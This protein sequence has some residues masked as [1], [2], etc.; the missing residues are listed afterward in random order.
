VFTTFTTA[1]GMNN[2][3]IRAIAQ[4][5]KG[6]MWFGGAVGMSRYDGKSFVNFSSADGLAGKDVFGL[7]FDHE[8]GLW[9][10]TS[11]GVS[12]YDQ[13]SVT[14][15]GEQ[16]GLDPGTVTSIVSTSDDNVWFKVGAN[17]AKLSRFDGKRLVKLTR[18][19]GLPG[20]NPAALY[21]DRDGA[22]LVSD[23]ETGRPVAR[24]DPASGSGERIRF[25]L[26]D[27]SGS[28]RAL[29]RSTTGELW[30]GRD[31]GAYIVGQPKES[32]KEIGRVQFAEPGRD[33]V[34]WFSTD[35]VAQNGGDSIW[36]YEPSTAPGGN[37]IWT[38]FPRVGEGRAYTPNV[39][40][41]LTLADGSLLAGT[42]NGA[43][44][45]DGKQF[46]PWPA[47]MPRLQ[48]LRI[49]NATRD[50]DGG[51][52]L[53]TAEGVFHTDGTAWNKLDLRDGLPENS[54]N[55]VHR[56]TD[57]TVWMGSF[58][59]GLARYRPIKHTPRSPLLTAQTDRDYTDVAALPTINT[60]QRVTFKFDVVDF[61]TAI[62]KRQYRWQLFQGARGEKEL[63]ANWQTPSNATQLEQTFAT[64]GAWTL[65]VQFIDR[66]LNYSKPTL[67]TFN[68]TLPWHENRA[69]IIPAA[70]GGVGL[71]SWA[72][73]AR[74]LYMRKRREAERLRERLMEEEHAAREAAELARTEIEAKNQLLEE[75]R[76]AADEA[77]RTKSQ[78]LANMSHELRTPMNAIIGYSE[79]LQEEAEDL[80]QKGFIPDL[81]KIHGAGKHL[82]GLINDILDLSKV[83]AGKMTLYLEEFDVAQLVHGVA[84]TVQRSL[85]G[86]KI[87]WWWIAPRISE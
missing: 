30:I 49:F 71:F 78:F 53:A 84:A 19:D 1:D 73:I 11:A 52:W 18:D 5:P 59:K 55:R 26:V 51:I 14:I 36:R 82:L 48:H 35:S 47:D 54:I 34:M 75:S 80:D 81:Q 60:S 65:A 77:N 23:V 74:L 72:L 31:A 2:N 10:A 70:V 50:A 57:G 39:H 21:L 4:D 7:Q 62:E 24:F 69:I 83:E 42:S 43:R 44:R 58:N 6:A 85:P 56:S 29:A 16:E 25:D 41:L 40:S 17:P 3:A 8:G 28:A 87:S 20:A 86:T 32:I 38:E 33:G 45:F 67:A 64:P 79:M 13:W 63:T 22:L 61:Y 46:A 66:D 12:H 15:L 37:G 68:V 9:A 27:G 76:A